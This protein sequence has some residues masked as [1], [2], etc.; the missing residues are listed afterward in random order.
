MKSKTPWGPWAGEVAWFALGI[1]GAVT[2]D[3]ACFVIGLVNTTVWA[4]AY[5]VVR[6]IRKGRN[7]ERF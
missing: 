3:E 1:F 7:E 6:E 4:A 2:G 5:E